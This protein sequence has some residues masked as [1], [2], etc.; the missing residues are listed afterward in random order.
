VPEEKVKLVLCGAQILI[1]GAAVDMHVLVLRLA[2]HEGFDV[3]RVFGGEAEGVEMV[4]GPRE[5]ARRA[6]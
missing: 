1:E 2:G 4:A 6:P 3:D 5:E